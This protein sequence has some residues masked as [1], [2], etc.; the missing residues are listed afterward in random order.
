MVS[1]IRKNSIQYHL[2]G[3]AV[4]TMPDIT[5]VRVSAHHNLRPIHPQQ[6]HNFF[7]ELRCVL[8]TLVFM[9]QKYNLPYSQ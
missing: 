4:V 1:G 9:S 5:P 3:D 6:A 7:P 2:A 8:Q